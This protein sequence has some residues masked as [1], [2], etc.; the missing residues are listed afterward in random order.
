MAIDDLPQDGTVETEAVE[1]GQ[2]IDGLAD[3]IDDH[4][5]DPVNEDEANEAEEEDAEIDDEDLELVDE[6]DEG[7]TSEEDVETD[8]K[9]DDETDGSEDYSGGRFAAHDAKVRLADG[10]MITVG[11]LVRNNLFQRDYTAKTTEHAKNVE[12]FE[13]QRAQVNQLEDQVKQQQEYILWYAQNYLPADPGRFDGDAAQDPIGYN[14]HRQ[15]QDAFEDQ[16]KVLE[17]FEQ[18]KQQREYDLQLEAA[19]E[20][21]EQLDSELSLLRAKDPKSFGTDAQIKDFVSKSVEPAKKHYGFEEQDIRGISDHRMV[22]ALKDALA[23][24]RL[25]A[26]APEARERLKGK[27]V[28]VKKGQ[29]RS[30]ASNSAKAAKAR[31]DRLRKTG[32]L[33]DGAESLMDF[34]L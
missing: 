2:D 7:E 24:R 13:A 32:S 34:N 14:A 28:I 8:V 25:K 31:F 23:Y 20:Y 26:K 9:D 29:R 30:Q 22:L 11:E 6:D 12:A 4:E 15:K 16:Q 18:K 27:P 5:D 10:Q 21:Q 19:K 1:V 3:L 33:E 17:Y